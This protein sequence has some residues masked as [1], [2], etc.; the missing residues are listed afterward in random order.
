MKSKGEKRA[1]ELLPEYVKML[2]YLHEMADIIRNKS[3]KMS[4]TAWPQLADIVE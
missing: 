4:Y 1:E 2:G 3:I